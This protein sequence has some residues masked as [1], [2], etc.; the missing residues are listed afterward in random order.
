[1]KIE[2]TEEKQNPQ[3]LLPQ[4][5]ERIFAICQNDP[6]FKLREEMEQIEA[7]LERVQK[8]IAKQEYLVEQSEEI[9]GD[10]IKRIRDLQQ[11]NEE[12]RVALLESI[13]GEI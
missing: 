1:V 13:G 5:V 6:N 11:L 2:V 4:I 10:I 9:K 7:L 12:K 8:K 3:E